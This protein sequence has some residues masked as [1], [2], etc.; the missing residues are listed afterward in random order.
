MTDRAQFQPFSVC[1]ISALH[2]G[3]SPKAQPTHLHSVHGL[4]RVEPALPPPLCQVLSHPRCLQLLQRVQVRPGEPLVLEAC[5][6]RET[7]GAVNLQDGADAVKCRVG[8]VFEVRMV[9]AD[10][11]GR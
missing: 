7:P 11:K 3:L 2:S 9:E 6:R 4:D 10:G 5:R 1:A 8:N